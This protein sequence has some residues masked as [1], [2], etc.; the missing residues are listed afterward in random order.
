MLYIQQECIH[1]LIVV[2]KPF[3]SPTSI[4]LGQNSIITRCILR[5]VNVYI[6]IHI[7]R[8]Y[9]GFIIKYIDEFHKFL[10]RNLVT[11]FIFELLPIGV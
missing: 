5:V 7:K 11:M 4:L 6:Y 3:L 8:E 1:S 10:T 2:E 9:C